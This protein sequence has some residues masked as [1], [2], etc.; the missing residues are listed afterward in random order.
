MCG[1]IVRLLRDWREEKAKSQEG[2]ICGIMGRPEKPNVHCS[3]Y[4]DHYYEEHAKFN[5]HI[6]K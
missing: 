3:Q 1:K 4:G 2:R 6:I 5:Y